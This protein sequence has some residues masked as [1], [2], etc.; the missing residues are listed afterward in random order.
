MDKF[1]GRWQHLSPSE[2]F[3]NHWHRGRM[4]IYSLT[5]QNNRHLRIALLKVQFDH[6]VKEN[7][8]FIKLTWKKI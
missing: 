1:D 4:I 3:N 2:P 8:T 5:Y 6:H 7:F